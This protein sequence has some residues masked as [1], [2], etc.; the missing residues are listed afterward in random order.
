MTSVVLGEFDAGTPPAFLN[1]AQDSS[2]R[3]S[4]VAFY[5]F[6]ILN[7]PCSVTADYS[8]LSGVSWYTFGI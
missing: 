5:S 1:C 7:V 3:V 4:S 6:L 8:I 2:L